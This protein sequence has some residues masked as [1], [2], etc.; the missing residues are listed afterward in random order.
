MLLV[1]PSLP[2]PSALFPLISAEL[3]PL[4]SSSVQDVEERLRTHGRRSIVPRV[5]SDPRREL[6]GQ[7]TAP[8]SRPPG[9]PPLLPAPSGHGREVRRWRVRYPAVGQAAPGP[10]WREQGEGGGQRP[11]GCERMWVR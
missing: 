10:R 1:C 4:L 5:L 9:G 3:V 7:L 8:R 11:Q 2:L 6:R